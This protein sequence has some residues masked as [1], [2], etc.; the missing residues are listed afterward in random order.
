MSTTIDRGAGR[1][2]DQLKQILETRQDL[3]PEERLVL[4]IA[5][6]WLDQQGY[7]AAAGRTTMTPATGLPT[8]GASSS[9]SR[10]STRRENTGSQRRSSSTASRPGSKWPLFPVGTPVVSV[11]R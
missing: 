1:L 11:Q 7:W 6:S 8:P 5:V 2:I 3:K 9:P 10:N 4:K